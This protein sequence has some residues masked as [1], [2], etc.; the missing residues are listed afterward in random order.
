MPEHD[1]SGKKLETVTDKNGVQTRRWKN[2][3][4]GDGNANVQA[5]GNMKRQSA[6]AMMSN[7]EKDAMY[8]KSLSPE[9]HREA[10]RLALEEKKKG[11]GGTW[12]SQ[13]TAEQNRRIRREAEELPARPSAEIEN[14][15]LE[16]LT[17]AVIEAGGWEQDK[18]ARK[19]VFRADSIGIPG[20][21]YFT[22]TLR[23]EFDN[24]P[25]MTSED[26]NARTHGDS[27]T[28][29]MPVPKMKNSLTFEDD[30]NRP[31]SVSG[32]H[33]DMADLSQKF[34]EMG[35]NAWV[36]HRPTGADLDRIES[37]HTEALHE[38]AYCI[39]EDDEYV[40]MMRGLDVE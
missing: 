15:G 31:V 38:G 1:K 2:S 34:N 25:L 35:F 12:K 18:E 22:P 9:R 32:S 24:D 40:E 13:S 21:G 17:D 10:L 27:Y 4:D 3:G 7:S 30:N 16:A 11:K 37:Q 8:L 29:G 5:L 19:P 6:Y 36:K 20:V 26:F 39:S 14:P 33:G 23:T 28:P